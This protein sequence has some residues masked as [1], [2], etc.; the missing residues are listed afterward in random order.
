M[1]EILQILLI[2]YPIHNMFVCSLIIDTSLISLSYASFPHTYVF[3][4]R[5]SVNLRKESHSV[6]DGWIAYEN[7][8]MWKRGVSSGGRAVDL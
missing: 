7:V 4:V 6:G 1:G 2:E 8:R 5:A 3:R